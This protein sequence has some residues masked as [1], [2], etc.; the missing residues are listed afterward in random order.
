[1]NKSKKCIYN[2][3][4]YL[5]SITCAINTYIDQFNEDED[6]RYLT[7]DQITNIL[8]TCNAICGCNCCRD[9]IA[10]MKDIDISY[11]Q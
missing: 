4:L 7:E 11:T 8:E 3:L 6:D 2:K 5:N 1:M 10:I 9:Q